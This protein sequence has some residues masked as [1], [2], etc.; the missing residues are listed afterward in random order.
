MACDAR[1]VVAPLVYIDR[2]IIR[3]LVRFVLSGAQIHG[4]VQEVGRDQR[5]FDFEV[6]LISLE[7]FGKPCNKCVD[8]D[9]V[10]HH[11]DAVVSVQARVLPPHSDSCGE[12]IL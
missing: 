11:R 8:F 10:A 3:L 9:L 4:D 7:D 5:V 6:K 1:R 12:N 2:L